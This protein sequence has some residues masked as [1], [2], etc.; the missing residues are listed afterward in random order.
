MHTNILSFTLLGLAAQALLSAASPH[1]LLPA[2]IHA[3]L[4]HQRLHA[5]HELPYERRHVAGKP[6]LSRDP[7]A[8]TSPST[9]TLQSEV[10]TFTNWM[11]TFLASP[12]ATNS[13]DSIAQVKEE[14]QTHATAVSSFISSA[15]G[16]DTGSISQLQSELTVFQGWADAWCNGAS[17]ISSTDAIAQ[18]KTEVQ[19]YEGWLAAWL[20]NVSGG[21]PAPVA[22]PAPVP[23]PAPAVPQ[24]SSTTE[25][26]PSPSTQAVVPPSPKPE[27]PQ[28]HNGYKPEPEISSSSSSAA[29]EAPSPVVPAYQAPPQQPEPT[30]TTTPTPS[31]QAASPPSGYSPSQGSGSGFGYGSGSTGST[32]PSTGS[33]HPKLAAWWGQTAA[34]SSEGLASVC[35]DDAFDV[36]IIAFLTNYFGPGGYPSLN[37][38]PSAAACS[39]KQT[40][41]GASGLLDGS[42]LAPAIKTC[43]ANGKKVLLSLGGAAASGS[44]H[45]GTGAPTSVFGSDQQGQQFAQTLWDLFL[46]G[47]SPLRPF[48]D[49]KLDGIDMGKPNSTLTFVYSLRPER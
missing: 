5:R 40:A 25:A 15:T 39:E 33:D 46:G 41:A 12:N 34:A 18:L 9:Q 26:A 43:Q 20:S 23:A 31:P 6:L 13:A 42:T 8:S 17:T 29:A 36:V 4:N 24:V 21:A 38:G 35:A 3:P 1:R 27:V 28:P 7:P 14:V 49:I 30:T 45:S 37:L 44:A 19:S 47:Q 16:I 2:N 32:S 11:S 22:A 10:T 48:G